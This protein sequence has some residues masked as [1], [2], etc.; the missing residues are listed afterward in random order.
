M[1]SVSGLSFQ[2]KFSVKINPEGKKFISEVIPK[3]HYRDVLTGKLMKGT[4]PSCKT[5]VSPALQTPQIWVKGQGWYDTQ[6][7]KITKLYSDSYGK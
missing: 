7:K 6:T 2:G 5:P 3:G 1:N 4:S